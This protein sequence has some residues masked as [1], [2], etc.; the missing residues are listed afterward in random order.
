MK[1]AYRAAVIGCGFMGHAHADAFVETPDVN[2]VAAADL[3]E[4]ARQNLGARF[5][6][7]NLYDDAARMI[8][9]ER[10]DL[11]AVCTSPS[12][13]AEVAGLACEGGALAVIC[14]KPMALDLSDADRMLAVAERTGTVLLI[15]HQRRFARRFVE[16]RRLIDEGA[17]GDVI[18]ITARCCFDVLSSGT[19]AVDMVRFLAHDR[20]INAVFGAIDMSPYAFFAPEFVEHGTFEGH[21]VETS[22]IATLVFEDGMRAHLELGE[23]ARPGYLALLIDGTEGRIDV[24]EIPDGTPPRLRYRS[25]EGDWVVPDWAAASGA[26]PE[27]SRDA[28]MLSLRQLL[29]ILA[30]GGEHSLNAGSG[31]A[32]LEVLIAILESARRR[33]I[34]RLPMSIPGS[35]L[36]AMLAA[37]EIANNRP[38]AMDGFVQLATADPETSA[39]EDVARALVAECPALPGSSLIA[40][41]K[42]FSQRSDVFTPAQTACLE[43]A[44]ALWA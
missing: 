18:Q 3:R 5:G 44:L 23:L 10:P 34:V 42:G 39:V 2:L 14:E 28:L 4:D 24:G 43:R 36:D 17:I 35:P 7:E 13:H 31:R 37:G 33:Q 6:V 40:L 38:Q 19:H 9:V 21:P 26:W 32:D 25:R 30:R 29:E 11:V 41:T 20:P 15:S 12:S 8:Q 22:A 16:A 27:D 1:R